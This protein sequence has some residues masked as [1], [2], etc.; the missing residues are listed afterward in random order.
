[1]KMQEI[2]DKVSVLY[3]DEVRKVDGMRDEL[4]SIINT[5]NDKGNDITLGEYK[6]LMKRKEKVTE[7]I[8]QL[9]HYCDGISYVRELLMDLGF[10]T[11]VEE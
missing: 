7:D 3:R 6:D 8:N 5:L 9:K 4:Y 10:E 2:I 11:K 1:M